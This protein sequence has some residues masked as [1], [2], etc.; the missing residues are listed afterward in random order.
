MST[1]T[2]INGF[3]QTVRERIQENAESLGGVR[4]VLNRDED[5]S[6]IA[7]NAA[8]LPTLCVFPMGA[9]KTTVNFSMSQGGEGQIESQV[10]V[11]GYYKMN[12]DNKTPYQDIDAIRAYSTVLVD[13]F[14]GY[15]TDGLPKFSFNNCVIYKATIEVSPYQWA[16]YVLDRYVVTFFVKAI[17]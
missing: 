10:I 9:G 15:D 13:L 14:K 2:V 5:P 12:F 8:D 11:A 1:A 3:A 4:Q 16:D 7:K 17:E 6:I